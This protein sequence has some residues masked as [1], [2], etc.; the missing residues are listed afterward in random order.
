MANEIRVTQQINV[1]N[2]ELNVTY[3]SGNLA[4][5]FDQAAV[6]G[7]T[8]GY[9]TIGTSEESETFS[10][11]S[12]LGWLMMHNLDDTNFVEWGFAT[13][14]YGGRLEPGEKAL[15]RLNPGTTLYLKADTAACKMVLNA[16]ED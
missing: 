2:G 3:P 7:P 13:G 12:T 6:G 10:E 9:V 15:F 1:Q 5:T 4:D 8:P 11:L 16:F 14:D